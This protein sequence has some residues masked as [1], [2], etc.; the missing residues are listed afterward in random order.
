MDYLTVAQKAARKAGT[1]HM[2]YFRSSH[3]IFTKS[4]SFN[5]LT[6]ADTEAER[7]IVSFIK[8][9]FPTHNFFGEEYK[10]PKTDSDY[11]WIIDP[12][13]GTNNFALGFPIFCSSIALTYKGQ[14]IVGVVYDPVRN[15]L[16]FAQKGNGAFLNGR[17]IYVNKVNSLKRAILI[18]GFYYSRGKEMIMTLETI[19]EFLLKH[20]VGIRRLG[21]AALDLCY[22][23]SGRAA[24][25]WEFELNPWDFAAGKLIIEEAGG[26]VTG[27]SGEDI[28][29]FDK[30]FIV[31]SNG[32]IHSS[33]LKVINQVH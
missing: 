32:I 18:T 29:L 30:N 16:F 15:E 6:I 7:K 1:V 31:A 24:G 27:K 11:C 13:D 23:A 10:Y 8:E 2:K 14:L 26:K 33:M 3:K 25:F 21:A 28:F 4:N 19:K 22:V 17:R 12:L 9:K 20:V 5:L